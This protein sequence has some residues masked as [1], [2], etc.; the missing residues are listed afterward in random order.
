VRCAGHLSGATSSP[1][2]RRC[3]VRAAAAA[4]GKETTEEERA[5]YVAAADAALVEYKEKLS[6][7][8]AHKR[9]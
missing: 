6:E 7:Y 3:V 1:C 8:N 4:P 5:K 2:L 9:E